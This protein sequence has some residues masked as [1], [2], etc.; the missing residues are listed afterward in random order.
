MNTDNLFIIEFDKTYDNCPLGRE[1]TEEI[2]IPMICLFNKNVISEEE[3]R[4]IL[5][6]GTFVYNLEDRIVV[7]Y[8]RQY[9]NLCKE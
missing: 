4:K 8:K 5:S 3:V 1:S 7:M 2:S 9:D 6:E